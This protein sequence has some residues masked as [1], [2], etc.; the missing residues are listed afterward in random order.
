[1]DEALELF[2][3]VRIWFPVEVNHLL[4][5]DEAGNA[6]IAEFDLDRKMVAFRRTEAQLIL[7]NSAYQKGIANIRNLCWRYR[8]AEVVVQSKAPLGGPETVC[9][10]TRSMRQ[11]SGSN[12]TLWTSYFDITARQMDLRLRSEEFQVPHTFAIGFREELAEG[13]HESRFRDH[14]NESSAARAHRLRW[15]NPQTERPTNITI[16]ALSSAVALII[17]SL[18]GATV[19]LS[20]GWLK[21]RRVW[22]GI[23]GGTLGA[24]LGGVGTSVV[25][26]LIPALTGW[27]KDFFF[28][29]DGPMPALIV[30]PLL[31][32]V[33]AVLGAVI[34][35]RRQDNKNLAG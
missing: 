30:V 6:A 15:E 24:L 27:P 19:A 4:I 7:T 5:A 2:R 31:A 11:T 12:R 20:M 9:E 25:V 10:I 22:K 32:I 29:G 33:F 35:G 18:A 13:K 16:I 17:G 21:A 3:A 8:N 26:T 1:V 34:S 28:W 14:A 23:V